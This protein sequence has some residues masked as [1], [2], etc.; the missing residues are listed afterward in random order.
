M[1]DTLSTT[2]MVV[3]TVDLVQEKVQ[4]I[5]DYF[6]NH[7]G[8]QV[9]WRGDGAEALIL[10]EAQDNVVIAAF[11]TYAGGPQVMTATLLPGQQGW[12]HGYEGAEDY[13]G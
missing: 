13:E 8:V 11:L 3:E 7:G 6:A 10:P 5:C 4:E 2:R 9:Y 1:Q 12:A